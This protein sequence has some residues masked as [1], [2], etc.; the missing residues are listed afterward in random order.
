MIV[1]DLADIPVGIDNRYPY[2][3]K[4]TRGYLTD[5]PPAFTVSVDDSDIEREHATSEESFT[6][7]YL[8]SIVAYRKIAERLPEYGA[9]VFHGAVLCLDGKA[10]AFTAPSGV[11]K[12]THTRLWLSELEGAYYINGDKPVIRIVDGT[13]RA[14]GTPWR[15]KEGYGTNRSAPLSAVALL[16]R[17]ESNTA[18]IIDKSAATVGL[19]KQIYI[20]KDPAAAALAMRV[21]DRIISSVRIF[22]LKCNME[23][24]AAVI[25]SRAMID[26][27]ITADQ[28]RK[29]SRKNVKT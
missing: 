26:D 21:A 10:Y 7:G 19:V 8:E 5:E 11:G 22:S 16:E 13:P 20:P 25:A 17:G 27:P 18:D 14:Y 28:G 24:E 15:G 4:L 29:Y 1:I 23:P 9:V 6:D 2:L 12:T 3:E